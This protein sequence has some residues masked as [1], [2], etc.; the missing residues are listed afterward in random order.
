[1]RDLLEN[2]LR[3]GL[4]PA[5]IL[6]TVA[7]DLTGLFGRVEALWRC[8]C[9]QPLRNQLLG[10][11][12]G[13]PLLQHRI[14]TVADQLGRSDSTRKSM[15]AHKQK[16]DWHIQRLYRIRNSIVHGGYVPEDLTHLASHLATYLWV[17]LRS[18]LDDFASEDGTRDIRK[19]FDK[20]LE[21]YDIVTRRL[22]GLG[23]S[24]P[25]LFYCVGTNFSMALRYPYG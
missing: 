13:T 19:F 1:M 2:F 9:N 15:E 16:I 20:H 11:A 12:S 5:P 24:D 10:V 23:T 7:T 6:G 25:P 3:L 14:Q 22:E 17:L 21:L 8:I 18:I 4:D